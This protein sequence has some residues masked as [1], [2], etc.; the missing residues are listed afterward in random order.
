M[1]QY[2]MRPAHGAEGGKGHHAGLLLLNLRKDLRGSLQQSHTSCEIVV[3][4]E[5]LYEKRWMNAT[6]QKN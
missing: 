4:K 1:L 3:A 2:H 6:Y 5:I